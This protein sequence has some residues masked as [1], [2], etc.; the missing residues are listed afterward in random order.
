M[1][2]KTIASLPA[3]AAVPHVDEDWWNSLLMEEERWFQQERGFDGGPPPAEMS[4]E[5]EVDWDKVTQ[6]YAL[7]DVVEAEAY[8]YNQGGVLVRNAALQGFVPVSHL[9]ATTE[10]MI[11]GTLPPDWEQIHAPD[12][13][14]P[15]LA[16]Y[17]GRTLR[18]KI[19]EC[20]PK[21]GRIVLSERSAQ[22]EPGRR[23]RLLNTIQP[24]E[25]AS[26]RVTN[27]TR[28]GVFVDL[29]GL[30]GLIHISELSWGRVQHPAEVVQVGQELTVHVIRV[31][32]EHNRIALSLKRLHP[33]PWED[34]ERRY[35]VGQVISV[36][37]TSVVSFGAFARV[38][39]GL[40]GLIHVSE[41]P[42]NGAPP[43]PWRVV[44][45]GETVQA[46]IVHIDAAR[47]RMGLSL[48]LD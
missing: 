27:I 12:V 14:Q 24:G 40:D 13:L 1:V 10:A 6:A 43:K 5:T 46:R 22:S 8:G 30:E 2:N 31:D 38:E 15:I 42:H 35:Q 25:R 28:F 47:Q 19:I 17:V 33:N 21:R 36:Q 16:A 48:N 26:G 20:N 41:M 29:G 9:V 4:L 23:T 3:S 37:V 7:D 18:L 44:Q 32:R 11:N 34:V 45:E 39:E